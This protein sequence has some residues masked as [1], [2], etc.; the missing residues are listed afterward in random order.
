MG[1]STTSTATTIPLPRTV[2]AGGLAAAPPGS[3][4]SLPTVL[5]HSTPHRRPHKEPP[6]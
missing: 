2:T 5:S 4:G 3:D 1:R 6:P